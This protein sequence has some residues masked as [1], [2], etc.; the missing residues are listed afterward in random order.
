MDIEHSDVFERKASISLISAS[1][2]RKQ[3]NI[4]VESL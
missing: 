4:I 1:I 3:I 2:S